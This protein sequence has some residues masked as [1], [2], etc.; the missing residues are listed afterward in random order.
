MLKKKKSESKLFPEEIVSEMLKKRKYKLTLLLP[1]TKLVKKEITFPLLD[2]PTEI[3][4]HIIV[5][6]DASFEWIFVCK[7]FYEWR[8]KMFENY[9]VKC[10]LESAV[11]TPQLLKYYRKSWGFILKCLHNRIDANPISEK[12]MKGYNC[13]QHF[14][15]G[16]EL[17][18]SMSVTLVDK[19]QYDTSVLGELVICNVHTLSVSGYG[20]VRRMV[21]CS[22]IPEGITVPISNPLSKLIGARLIER[23]AKCD[24]GDMTTVIME[25]NFENHLLHGE[26]IM[27]ILHGKEASYQECMEQGIVIKGRFKHGWPTGRIELKYGKEEPIYYDADDF[28]THDKPVYLKTKGYPLLVPGCGCKLCYSLFQYFEVHI[29]K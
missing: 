3:I 22:K 1:K 18:S 25:G 16:T 7:M 24:D 19:I 15:L 27:I 28:E 4:Y 17:V 6:I 2:L 8:E 29:K 21:R 26:G 12:Y 13:I 23:Y 11:F 9:Y 14:E 10:E 20:M 5:N